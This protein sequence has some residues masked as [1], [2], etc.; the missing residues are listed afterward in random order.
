MRGNTAPKQMLLNTMQQSDV[1]TAIV[2]GKGVPNTMAR[3]NPATDNISD[4][5]VAILSS[6]IKNWVCVCELS[7]PRAR[8]RMTL[9]LAWL[10]ALPPAPTNMVRKYITAVAPTQVLVS[11]GSESGN[12]E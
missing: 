5:A 10:P 1:V 6:R 2:S 7:V 3:T 9:T 11:R 8:P 4:K 12:K